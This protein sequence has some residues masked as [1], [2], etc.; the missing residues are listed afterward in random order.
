[1]F[2]PPITIQS[3]KVAA[4]NPFLAFSL[5]KIA[6]FAVDEVKTHQFFRND[7][8]KMPPPKHTH[9]FKPAADSLL[10]ISG[11]GGGVEQL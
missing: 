9:K 2:L 5:F 10:G 1:M 6:S 3:S 4:F 11:R 7:P 8:P